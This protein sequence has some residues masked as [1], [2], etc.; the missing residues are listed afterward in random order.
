MTPTIPINPNQQ[1]DTICRGG[2]VIEELI[3]NWPPDGGGI[4]RID[5]NGIIS[6]VI[7]T[8]LSIPQLTLEERQANYKAA[9]LAAVTLADAKEAAAQWL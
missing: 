3:H 1:I 5:N 9:M 8:G 4:R 6:T 7:V 2:V